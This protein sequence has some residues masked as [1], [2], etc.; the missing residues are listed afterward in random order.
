MIKTNIYLFGATYGC[1]TY[2]AGTYQN[3][4][5]SST[6]GGTSGSANSGLLSNTGFDLLLIGTIAVTLILVA[7]IV[8]FWKRSGKRQAASDVHNA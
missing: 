4:T 2:G 3:G 5:C 6:G 8:R 1:G 7:L